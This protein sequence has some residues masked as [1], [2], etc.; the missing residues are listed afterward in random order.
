MDVFGF[1]KPYLH[2]TKW[3]DEGLAY[4]FDVWFLQDQVNHQKHGHGSLEFV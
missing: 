4:Q 2:Y 3:H 1:E